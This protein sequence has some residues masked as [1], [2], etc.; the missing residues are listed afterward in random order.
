MT[1]HPKE[2]AD[3]LGSNVSH[4]QNKR[5]EKAARIGQQY[6]G[7]S[8]LKGYRS[9]ITRNS[10]DILDKS[11]KSDKSGAVICEAGNPGMAVGGMGDVLAGMV[12]GFIAQKVPIFYAAVL[13]VFMHAESA[14]KAVDKY[15]QRGLLPTDLFD[16]FADI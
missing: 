11:D 8:I 4:V 14:D 15:G 3:L 2:A 5:L 13:A 12:A 1:P 10:D 9:I 16:Y 7:V 6:G